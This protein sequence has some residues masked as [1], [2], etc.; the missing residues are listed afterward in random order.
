[1]LMAICHLASERST[2]LR[3]RVGAII[4]VDGR[5]VSIGYNGAPSG[6]PHC[7]PD[8]CGPDKPCLNTVHAEANAI[9]WAARKGIA[10]EDAWLYC[11]YSPCQKCAE[12][13]LASGIRHLV[14]ERLYRD[15]SPLDYMHYSI[16]YSSQVEMYQLDNTGLLPW[17]PDAA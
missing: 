4:A 11:V 16:A 8:T 12:L 7:N 1:M 6:K 13:I 17:N 5:P 3:N 9:A 2:C 15:T 10:T 14:F